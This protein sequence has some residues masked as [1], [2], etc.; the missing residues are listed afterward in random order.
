MPPAC[1][2]ALR[3]NGSDSGRVSADLENVIADGP[4]AVRECKAA[5]QRARLVTTTMLGPSRFE[6]IRRSPTGASGHAAL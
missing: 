1:P 2:G 5:A 4:K 3:R 6:I